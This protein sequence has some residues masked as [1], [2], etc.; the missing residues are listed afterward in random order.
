[1][2]KALTPCTPQCVI[3]PSRCWHRSLLSPDTP[4]ADHWTWARCLRFADGPDEVHMRSVARMEIKSR[5]GQR[6]STAPYL[7]P[8]AS[9]GRHGCRRRSA[10]CGRPGVRVIRLFDVG[11]DRLSRL[12][13][14]SALSSVRVLR[15]SIHLGWGS[16]RVPW[17][18]SL[19]T[20]LCPSRTASTTDRRRSR[21]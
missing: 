7:L 14:A 20:R 17:S 5:Q 3:V 12:A 16:P 2:I 9:A 19:R 11:V 4:L 21:P 15:R 6:G 18:G 10:W 8:L 1:M 13:P